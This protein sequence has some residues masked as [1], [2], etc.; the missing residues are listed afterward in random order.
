MNVIISIFG[1]IFDKCFRVYNSYRL[2]N[3]N[4]LLGGGE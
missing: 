1:Y 4:E 3:M 2:H